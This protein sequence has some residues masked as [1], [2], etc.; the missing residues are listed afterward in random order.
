MAFDEEPYISEEQQLDYDLLVKLSDEIEKQIKVS[1]SLAIDV[2]LD[3]S[4]TSAKKKRV[5]KD[6][7][8]TRINFE[9][10]TLNLKGIEYSYKDLLQLA[11]K[12]FN[13]RTFFGNDSPYV[14]NGLAFYENSLSF[15][16]AI[17]AF[18][19]YRLGH[20]EEDLWWL[21]LILCTYIYTVLSMD[22]VY[23]SVSH[24]IQES[25][26]ELKKLSEYVIR[27][28]NEYLKDSEIFEY[29]LA[30]DNKRDIYE[31][32][33]SDAGHFFASEDANDE[34][35]RK[36]IDAKYAADLVSQCSKSVYLLMSTIEE[37]DNPDFATH[38]K[39]LRRVVMDI[40]DIVYGTEDDSYG[41]LKKDSR[42]NSSALELQEERNENRLLKLTLQNALS[43]LKGYDTETTLNKRLASLRNIALMKSEEL[44]E[45]FTKKFSF[46]LMQSVAGDFDVYYSRLKA[47][48]GN[49]YDLL[50]GVALK[51]LASAEYLYDIFVK[52]SAPDGFDY[53]GIAVLYFQ[54]FETA[55][56]KLIIEPYT[57]WLK[58]QGVDTLYA[59]KNII[60]K[61][62]KSKK[63]T[64][65]E[66]SRL[67]F[68]DKSLEQ[69]FSG[70]F[71]KDLFY[72]RTRGEL[73]TS[74]EIGKFQRFIDLFDCINDSITKKGKLLTNY[75]EE[76][77][78]KKKI[79]QELI[80]NFASAVKNA[81]KPRN[82]AAHGLYGLGEED[83][84]KDKIIVYDETNITDIQNFKNLL[85][86]FLEFYN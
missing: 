36:Q 45:E 23:K 37:M 76:Q 31:K 40:C 13:D 22:T 86:A 49:K 69:Y 30:D 9:C 70:K 64:Q 82:K 55:Y 20:E 39:K 35:E 66:K 16:D 21:S 83:V 67:S 80:R 15:E 5:I 81:T 77:C 29:R 58:T 71:D 34:N 73:V 79:N 11:E 32:I 48:L 46:V 59:E 62:K 18:H 38:L 44:V 26:V 41:E 61:N 24:N 65:Q 72:D 78:F 75:L 19:N 84:R 42:I 56:D 33:D 74:L 12:L 51:A 4:S 14:M 3:E 54:A 68:I 6:F 52:R 60:L 85:Y 50:P 57:I 43:R 47:E 2:L 17:L 10:Q 8:K 7:V 28:W 63:M 53:S 25:E 27:F 1:R